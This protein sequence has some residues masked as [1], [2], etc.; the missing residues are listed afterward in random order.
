M[1]LQQ[2]NSFVQ[3]SKSGMVHGNSKFLTSSAKVDLKVSQLGSNINMNSNLGGSS[4]GM[5]GQKGTSSG[6][7]NLNQTNQ[8]RKKSLE[9]NDKKKVEI[10]KKDQIK[11]VILEDSED[12][13]FLNPQYKLEIKY[14][15]SILITLM[16]EDDIIMNKAYQR[17]NF[18]V[19]LSQV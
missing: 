1:N 4:L 16:Q 15:S 5:I 19:M 9:K 18:V 3:N 2:K 8:T 10:A 7:M 6:N 17:C 14:G 13:W 11:R 12:R